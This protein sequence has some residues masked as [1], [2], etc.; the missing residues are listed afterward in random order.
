MGRKITVTRR[1]TF[2]AAHYLPGHDGKC[3]NLH[4][5]TYFL[6]VTVGRPGGLIQGGS[7]DGMVIDFSDLKSIIG[8]LVVDPL[9]HQC[10]NELL[11][12]RPTAENMANHFF[13]VLSSALASYEIELVRIRLWE[14]PDSYAEVSSE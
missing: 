9:D 6:D 5:H 8:K 11:P 2:D 13:D 4:G 10:L 7:S 14:T 3:Q 1:F 12:Y